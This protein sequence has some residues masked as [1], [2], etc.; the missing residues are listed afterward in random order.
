MRDW[1]LDNF[2]TK[3]PSQNINFTNIAELVDRVIANCHQWLYQLLLLFLL[4]FND[5]FL[6]LFVER[7]FQR[8]KKL[9][10]EGIESPTA[11]IA[12]ISLRD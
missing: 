6:C 11:E 10:S 7:E 12:H 5:F 3:M 1:N 2:H 8:I 9:H 4:A